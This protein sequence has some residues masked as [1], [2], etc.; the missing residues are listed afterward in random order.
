MT[1][2]H[3]QDHDPYAPLRI[4]DFRHYMLAGM[5]STVGVQMQSVA[6]GWELYK[7]TGSAMNLGLVGLVQFVPLLM[8]ALPAGHAADRYSRKTILLLAQGMLFSASAGLALLSYWQGPVWLIYV[9]L[10]LAGMAQAV[11]RP[12]RWSFLPRLVPEGQLAGAVTWN[13]SGWQTSAVIG[14]ALA[15]LFLGEQA[16]TAA[17]VY[18]ADVGC[19]VAAFA[20]LVAIR[21]RPAPRMTEQFSL[22]T[23]VAGFEFVRK[24]DLILAAISLDM[25][26]VLLG[27]AT[28][29]LPIYAEDILHVGHTGLGWLR[30]APALGASLMALIQAHRPPL[31]RAGPTLL[32]AVAGF[33]A[34]TI[35]FGLSRDPILSF[36]MLLLTGA[37]DN[38]SV[39]VRTTLVQALTP[40][41]MRGR[42]SAVNGLF[43]GSSNELGG[44]ESGA[45]AAVFGPVA[46]VVG[47]GIGTILVVLAAARIWPR[48]GQLGALHELRREADLE[49][50]GVGAPG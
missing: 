28:A 12:A 29:L 13:T 21:N 24:S 34:A 18:L 19:C 49:P 31:R 11:N 3:A 37:L 30:A 14:P 20:L 8:L 38:I 23:L 7:R 42:V 22:R 2:G 5:I 33:G 16:Q 17:R 39:V 36:V 1:R 46:S 47:G 6:V 48:L 10:L 45:T 43:I 41:A 9:C 32:W 50:A 27:G 26:A 15:G 40:D 35:V 44:F 25:F 4:A